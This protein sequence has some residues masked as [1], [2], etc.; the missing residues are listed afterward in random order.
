L[1]DDQKWRKPT[2]KKVTPKQIDRQKAKS[3]K[4]ARRKSPV[5]FTTSQLELVSMGFRLLTA[6]H[7]FNCFSYS[8]L[9][10]TVPSVG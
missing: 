7:L 9:M 5:I 3:L 6:S 4:R 8:E 10:A 1:G 2:F